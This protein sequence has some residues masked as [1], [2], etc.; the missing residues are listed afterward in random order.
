MAKVCLPGS[1]EEGGPD[2]RQAQGVPPCSP[3]WITKMQGITLL[4]LLSMALAWKLA[5]F[6]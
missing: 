1:K 2:S 4:L 3:D 5:S 6:L